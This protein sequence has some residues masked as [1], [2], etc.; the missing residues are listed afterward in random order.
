MLISHYVI[1]SCRSR[2]SSEYFFLLRG[3]CQVISKV[4]ITKKAY[5]RHCI[6]VLLY[7]DW[8]SSI[9][10]TPYK[11]ATSYFT[12]LTTKTFNNIHLILECCL[13]VSWLKIWLLLNEIWGQFQAKQK[14]I[15][16]SFHTFPS[17]LSDDRQW[18][19]CILRNYVTLVHWFSTGNFNHGN[20]D[21]SCPFF[22]SHY[23][24]PN[25]WTDTSC[26]DENRC[27]QCRKVIPI[28]K[29]KRQRLR[30]ARYPSI[31][32]PYGPW[33]CYACGGPHATI[34]ARK[35]REEKT[36]RGDYLTIFCLS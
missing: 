6:S 24:H 11:T 19:D 14:F 8:Q 34:Q 10:F 1:Q 4:K 17:S 29:N 3:D 26:W 22:I 28:K 31:H 9:Y 16:I 33:V 36:L 21:F 12:I 30:A 13:L 5:A 32:S 35:E 27:G 20:T 25:L 15:P 18:R 7:F 23:C 2:I